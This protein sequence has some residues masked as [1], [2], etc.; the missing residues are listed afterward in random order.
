MSEASHTDERGASRPRG[1]LTDALV[2]TGKGERAAFREVYRLTAPKLFGICLRICGERQ[3]AEDVLNEVY[4]T[5]WNRAATFEPRRASPI[6][7]LATI[8]RNKAIDWRRAQHPERLASLDRAM[9][10]PDPAPSATTVI[11]AKQGTHA[12]RECLEELES[13]QSGPIREA[14]F[15]GRTYSEVAAAAGILATLGI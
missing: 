13:D 7:W 10:T 9:D 3:A 12:L 11:E 6:T 8:A 2:E 4:L 15:G 1:I 14:F 5:V